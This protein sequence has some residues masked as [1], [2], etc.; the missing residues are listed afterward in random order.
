MADKT[1]TY[2]RQNRS[3]KKLATR[4]HSK[5]VFEAEGGKQFER[6]LNKRD[7][8]KRRPRCNALKHEAPE[9]MQINYIDSGYRVD[10]E[11]TG[12]VAQT[13]CKCHNDTVNVWTHLV[14]CLVLFIFSIIYMT[15]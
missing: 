9:W 14:G 3:R 11:K 1:T 10:F 12:E 2:E 4:A 6:L 13:I 15:E 7:D 5:D 8:G